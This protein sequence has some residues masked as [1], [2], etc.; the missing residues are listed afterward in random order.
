[1]EST[2]QTSKFPQKHMQQNNE[3][4][5]QASREVLDEAETHLNKP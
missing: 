1:M 4:W 2:T 5:G 3:R